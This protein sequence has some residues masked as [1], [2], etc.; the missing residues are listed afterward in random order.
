[1][2]YGGSVQVPD[3]DVVFVGALVDT[4][5]SLSL[6][7]WILCVIVI[8]CQTPTELLKE[9]RHAL[10]IL[11]HLALHLSWLTWGF[12]GGMEFEIEQFGED[13]WR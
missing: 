12:G 6:V 1:M 4:P 10:V 2:H 9:F 7:E 13:S 8:E 11:L 3:E 5:V